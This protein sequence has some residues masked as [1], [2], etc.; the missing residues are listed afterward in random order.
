MCRPGSE[1]PHRRQQKFIEIYNVKLEQRITKYWRNNEYYSSLTNAALLTLSDSS[2]MDNYKYFL[3]TSSIAAKIDGEK[4]A[5]LS[6]TERLSLIV[7]T[8]HGL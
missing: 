6:A 5:L 7:N 3:L 1:E 8:K 4:Q 2:L